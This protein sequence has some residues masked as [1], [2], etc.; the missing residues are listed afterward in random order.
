MV[1][2]IFIIFD[3]YDGLGHSVV[4]MTMT[5]IE[6]KFRCCMENVKIKNQTIIQVLYEK[7]RKCQNQKPKSNY[8]SGVVWRGGGGADGKQSNWFHCSHNLGR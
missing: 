7:M 3:D 1:R 2:F 8:N 4:W 6:M 5:K